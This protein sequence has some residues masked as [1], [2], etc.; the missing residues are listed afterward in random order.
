MAI[1][2]TCPK[3]HHLSCKETLAGKPYKCPRCGSKFITPTAEEV[4]GAAKSGRL[5]K[6]SP[7]AKTTESGDSSITNRYTLDSAD[8][9]EGRAAAK[10]SSDEIIV[11]LCPNGHKLNGPKQL[12]GQPGQ[13]PHCGAKFRVPRSDESEE[14]GDEFPAEGLFLGAEDHAELTINET[15]DFLGTANASPEEE[16][17]EASPVP[18]ADAVTWPTGSFPTA[19]AH[20]LANVF[21][22][23]WDD[24][25]EDTVVELQMEHGETI[26]PEFFSPELSHQSHGVFALRAEDG[27]YT[28]ISVPWDSITRAVVQKIDKLPYGLFE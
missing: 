22:K 23:L 16:L 11:F 28:I 5:F 26:L 20:A 7:L 4:A 9:S 13:C 8:T 24:R 17:I 15:D 25:G 19:A 12:E 3:G 6:A 10:A 1:K 14:G 2:F 18:H 27:T 21:A